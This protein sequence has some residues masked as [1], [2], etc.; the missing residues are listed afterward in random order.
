MLNQK[1][2]GGHWCIVDYLTHM[3]YIDGV[4]VILLASTL[5]TLTPQSSCSKQLGLVRCVIGS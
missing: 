3:E 4:S 1:N 2:L 5:P